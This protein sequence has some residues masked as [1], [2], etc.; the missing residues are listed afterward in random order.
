MKI[1]PLLP[2]AW[3]VVFFM[4]LSI[5]YMTPVPQAYGSTANLRFVELVNANP[6][7]LEPHEVNPTIMDAYGSI[8]TGN[9]EVTRLLETNRT[10][11]VMQK[12]ELK[13]GSLPI[14]GML[15]DGI[16]G[17]AFHKGELRPLIGKNATGEDQEIVLRTLDERFEEFRRTSTISSSY[18]FTL[19]IDK[20]FF[21]KFPI[22]INE[23]G[24]YTFQFYQKL[25]FDRGSGGNNMGT[26]HVVEKYSRALDEDGRCTMEG[27]ITVIKSDYST[28]VC[29]S[30]ETM[31]ELKDRGWALA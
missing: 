16:T 22:K 5:V 31:R 27:F 29:T 21:V 1:A 13:E 4:S 14:D 24:I 23:I 11:Y 12:V 8:Y 26:F 3:L 25:E 18:E 20:P 19:D 30:I 7:I 6:V 28:V 15:I 17:Y 10:Y 2:V 9:M